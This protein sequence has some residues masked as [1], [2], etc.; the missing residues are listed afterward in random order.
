MAE[1]WLKLL[2]AELV[3]GCRS[4]R[5]DD[6]KTCNKTLARSKAI[7]EQLISTWK[8]LLTMTTADYR[9]FRGGLGQSSGFQSAGYRL[10]EFVLGNKDAAHLKVHEHDSEAYDRLVQALERPAIYDEVLA[11]LGPPG[12]SR[13]GQASPPRSPG[14]LC[15]RSR[16]GG[17]LGQDLPRA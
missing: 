4:I 13:A 9:A 15:R 12:I 17:D 5:A 2:H 6:I 3:E 16:G 1:L 7:L 10:V 8:V 11:Y 14:A